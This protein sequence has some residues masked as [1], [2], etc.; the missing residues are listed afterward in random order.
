MVFADYPQMDLLPV[1]SIE[2]T[3][4]TRIRRPRLLD[5]S[6]MLLRSV[7]DV[8]RRDSDCFTVCDNRLHQQNET[9]ALNGVRDA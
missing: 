7:S 2:P 1:L 8:L 3:L 5:R 6:V 9:K 4:N